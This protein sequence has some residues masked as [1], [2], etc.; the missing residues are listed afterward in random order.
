MS[1][2][3]HRLPETDPAMILRY[4]DRQFAAEL[5]AVAILHL[6]LFTWL[7]ERDGADLQ[8]ICD[9]FALKTRPADVMLTLA[10]ANGYLQ[11]HTD[12]HLEV[13]QLAIEHL[14]ARSPWY[15]GPY[16]E[17]LRGNNAY[18]G[19]LQVLQTDRPA[20]WQAKQDTDNWH[21]AMT[22]TAFAES[23]KALLHSRGVA[24]GQQNAQSLQIAGILQG[25]LLLD[26][27]GGSGI[28]SACLLSTAP[29][30]KAVVLEQPPV[31]QIAQREMS[32]FGLDHRC[33][34]LSGDMF[35]ANW[36]RCQVLLLSNVLHDWDIPEIRMLLQ[37]ASS[38][39]EP[40]G[41]LVVHEAFLGEEKDGPLPV[42]EYSA[43]LMHITQGRCYAPNEIRTAAEGL[44]L[45]WK[46]FQ[47]TIAD[48]GWL[49]AQRI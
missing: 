44:P 48:R 24:R 39:L 45:A 20:N 18:M 33:E 46:E 14:T 6:D 27:A 7:G 25:G 11:R 9:H 23:C 4:R 5:L 16:Y 13:T 22:Q 49:A 47:P 3:F 21:D 31:D 19:F 1:I 35:Q 42:A 17:P 41:W 40:G 26:V 36:P 10:V 12:G 38:A 29:Q 8:T 32:R 2:D 28:Y 30:L 34:V 37:K 43:L 15:L